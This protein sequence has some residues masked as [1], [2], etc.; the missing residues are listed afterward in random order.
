MDPRWE[1][2]VI[3]W[4]EESK[5]CLYTLMWVTL[6]RYT[7]NASCRYIL[8][9]RSTLFMHKAHCGCCL[10]FGVP[11]CISMFSKFLLPMKKLYISFPW[12]RSYRKLLNHFLSTAKSSLSRLFPSQRLYI[13]LVMCILYIWPFSCSLLAP[14][15]QS[16]Y[17]LTLSPPPPSLMCHAFSPPP[18]RALLECTVVHWAGIHKQKLNPSILESL[19]FSWDCIYRHLCLMIKLQA[20]FL[21]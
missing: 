12:K 6:R 5:C 2:Q 4:G 10:T 13:G 18:S 17:I 15:V 7:S 9:F 19:D 16:T 14:G 3:H 11:S 21:C 20:F 8:H 1:R